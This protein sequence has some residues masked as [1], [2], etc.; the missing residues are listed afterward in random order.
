[1]KDDVDGDDDERRLCFVFSPFFLFFFGFCVCARV[2]LI[3]LFLN[4]V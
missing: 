2:N 4:V 1:M 3:N